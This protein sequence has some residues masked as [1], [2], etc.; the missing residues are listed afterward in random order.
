MPE[1]CEHSTGMLQYAIW[2]ALSAEG[3]GCNLQHYNPV[4]DQRVGEAFGAGKDWVLKAQLVFGKR[5]GGRRLERTYQ[6]L[7]GERLFVRK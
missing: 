4:F 7:E 3:L 6:P 1:W 2:C 5:E